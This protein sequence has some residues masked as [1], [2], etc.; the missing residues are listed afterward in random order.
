MTDR[1]TI[2]AADLFSG[3]GGATTALIEACK[4]VGYEL[5]IVA[6]NHWP[7]AVATHEANYPRHVHYCEAVGKVNPLEAVPGGY[8]DVLLAGPECT[9]HS[10]AAG[11]KPKN[12]QS[13]ASAT[14]I[15]HFLELLDVRQV[16]IENVKEFLSWGPLNEHDKP[17]KKF[18]GYYFRLFIET[19]KELGYVVEWKVLK[20]SRYGDP[21]SRERFFLQAI[22]RTPENPNPTITWP[23]PTHGD[24]RE[25]AALPNLLP[26]RVAR[27]IVNLGN[28]S[29]SI[30]EREAHGMKPLCEN[31]LK[32]IYTGIRKY[33]GLPFLV[34]NFGEAK[35]QEPRTHDL[36]EPAPTVT[37][38]GAGALIEPFIV[39]MRTNCNAETLGEPLNTL[40]TSRGHFYLAEPSLVPY[41]VKNY[42]GSDAVSLNDPLPAICANWEHLGVTQPF[43]L[44]SGGPKGQQAP[45]SIDLP[46]RTLLAAPQ[47][48][49]VEPKP[50]FLGDFL[51]RYNGP[52]R[53]QSL[54]S[55]LTTLDTSNRF[56][57][58]QF[59]VEYYGES[60]T[61][62]SVSDPLGTITTRDRF[63][64]VSLEIQET[65]TDRQTTA[66]GRI[67]GWL[68]IKYRMLTVPE[69]AAAHSFPKNFVFLG[70]D[71]DQKKMIG[72]SWPV[73]LGAALC[74]EMLQRVP[75][76]APST[77]P[78]RS[79]FAEKV[80]LMI[81]APVVE[82][83]PDLFSEFSEKVLVTA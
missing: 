76:L 60:I 27:E 62:R 38:H 61:P 64:L 39:I 21:T 63:A 40:C 67:I 29:V 11:G 34:P 46:L 71:T 41:L 1:Q 32:R 77:A 4:A 30:Y 80:R 20:A 22:K 58:C 12:K 31:T 51:L 25:C 36:S 52:G 69:L 24:A 55:P 14:D 75:M 78:G 10:N 23:S 81:D 6:V 82:V 15:I 70:T 48:G 66:L 45:R 8:L 59:V 65:T 50:I 35:G 47:E 16:L 49:I 79:P 68:D 33:S 57:L 18:K 5:D 72:N 73:K 7:M 74:G 9:H 53:N 56:A 3:C 44:T 43:L 42:T 26:Q 13:R 54:D 19:L 17:I 37:S 2:Y 83:F 28:P